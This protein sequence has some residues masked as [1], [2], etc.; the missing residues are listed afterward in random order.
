MNL[1]FE[2]IR[3]GMVR[4]EM[5]MN[6]PM[7]TAHSTIDKRPIVLVKIET[8]L[9]HGIGECSALN[10]PYYSSQYLGSEEFV[11]QDFLLPYLSRSSQP[12]TLAEVLSLLSNIKGHHMAKAAVEMAFI[13]VVTRSESISVVDWLTEG[14]PQSDKVLAGVTIGIHDKPDITVAHI[15]TA[16]NEGYK[17]IKCKIMPGHDV[18]FISA[19]ITTFTDADNFQLI[20]DGNESYTPDE[21]G[22]KVLS[23]LANLDSKVI[24]IEQPFKVN[25]I[26]RIGDFRE[27]IN[28]RLLFDESAYD[29]LQIKIIGQLSLGDGIVI[30]S[31]RLGGILP[32]LSAMKLSAELGLDCSLGG[33]YEAGVARSASLALACLKEVTL[34]T[35]LGPSNHYYKMDITKPHSML[36]GYINV[37]NST[38]LGVELSPDPFGDV[39]NIEQEGLDRKLPVGDYLKADLAGNKFLNICRPHY[40]YPE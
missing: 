5:S 8:S 39:H 14:K 32:A 7:R 21:D 18:D 22:V 12:T 23:T 37:P 4:I 31:A 6:A 19:I 3:I 17:R 26:L 16:L 13:D 15:A 24:A 36:D 34:G 27:K 28:C 29:E 2:I 40:F 35:D 9:G 33:M 10:D 11:L 1:S 20:L 38:G 30:K 25:D